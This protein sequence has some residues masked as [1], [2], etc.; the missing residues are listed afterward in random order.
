MWPAQAAS[1]SALNA[2]RAQAVAEAVLLTSVRE[3]A[4]WRGHDKHVTG[5]DWSSGMDGVQVRLARHPSAHHG[6]ESHCDQLV[7]GCTTPTERRAH[8]TC[9]RTF[10]FRRV[11]DGVL[12]TRDAADGVTD[13][14]SS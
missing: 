10:L 4:L 14:R 7:P 9:L 11:C 5:L 13:L 1:I 3:V 12:E 6:C 8:V 2:S